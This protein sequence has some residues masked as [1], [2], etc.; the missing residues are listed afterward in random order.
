MPVERQVEAVAQIPVLQGADGRVD[1]VRSRVLGQGHNGGDRL[2]I[3]AAW[4][5]GRHDSNVLDGEVRQDKR[6]DHGPR[7]P[8]REVCQA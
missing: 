8:R 6:L 3:V 2:A 7:G 4:L 5:A 1:V